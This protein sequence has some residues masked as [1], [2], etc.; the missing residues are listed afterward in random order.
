MPPRRP[1]MPAGWYS[2]F[3]KNQAG[4]QFLAPASAEEFISLLHGV[5]STDIKDQC[6]LASCRWGNWR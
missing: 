6:A 4:V 2:S 3:K 5:H 1:A